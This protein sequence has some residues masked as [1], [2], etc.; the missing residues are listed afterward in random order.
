MNREEAKVL[1]ADLYT[2]RKM[3]LS[4]AQKTGEMAI[5]WKELDTSLQTLQDKIFL[6]LVLQKE[7]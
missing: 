4:G 2:I 3:C 7:V 1:E 5:K 6:E